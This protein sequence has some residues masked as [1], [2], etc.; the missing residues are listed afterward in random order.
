MEWCSGDRH[1]KLRSR[2][3]Q[4]SSFLHPS[5]TLLLKEKLIQTS[6][7]NFSIKLQHDFVNLPKFLAESKGEYYSFGRINF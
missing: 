3:T 4:L 2:Q 7:I 5:Q 1:I 6:I